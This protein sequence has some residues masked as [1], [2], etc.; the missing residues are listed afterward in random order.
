MAEGVARV[1]D[2]A[3]STLRPWILLGTMSVA[4]F[5]VNAAAFT[6][7]GVL[8]PYMVKEL[9]WGWT[10]AGFGFTI[11]GAATGLSSYF[12]RYLIRRHGV[13]AA[14]VAGTLAMMAGML[15]FSEARGAGLFY[16]GAVLCGIGY[17]TMSIIPS[18]Y[19]IGRVFPQ[20][21]LPIGIYFTCFALGGVCGPIIALGVLDVTGDQ[22]RTVWRVHAVNMLLWGAICTVMIGGAARLN[23]DMQ[24]AQS[25][26]AMGRD[27]K[28]NPAIWRTP[29]DWTFR[30]ALRAPQFWIL[31][32]AY[33][34]HMLVA[35]SVSSLS[36]PH[37]SQRGVAVTTA[38][39]ML[40]LEQLV[41]T[42]ARGLG[43]VLGNRIDPLYILMTGLFLLALGPAALTFA[44]NYPMLLLYAL[45]TG[46]GYGLTVFATVM[47]LLNYFGVTHNLEIFT[48]VAFTG[49]VAALGPAIGGALR[50]ATGNFQAGF[51]LFAGVNFLIFL[52]AAIMR[53]PLRADQAAP[54][55]A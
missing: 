41:Q 18:T 55:R 53:P 33:M 47:L 43:G 49:A 46:L 37:L 20:P 2:G 4:S 48:A 15:C 23:E 44:D 51:L 38:V 9:G 10:A 12:P 6:T 42:F 40:S 34:S 13:R 52:A 5:W 54:A 11:L 25:A 3:E 27:P 50:D 17:Q 14:L 26:S 19:V 39:A 36:I 24:R 16:L 32:A 31:A 8:L 7:L 28:S 22:W 45:A 21:S 1:A 29:V 35:I 30:Q